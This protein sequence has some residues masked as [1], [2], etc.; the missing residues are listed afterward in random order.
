MA[1]RWQHAYM[2][3][4]WISGW[5]VGRKRNERGY[6]VQPWKSSVPIPSR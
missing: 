2:P 1:R 3:S 5:S 6:R 4:H